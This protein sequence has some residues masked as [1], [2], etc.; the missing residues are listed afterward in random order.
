MKEILSYVGYALLLFLALTWTLGVRLKLGIAINVIFVAFCYVVACIVLPVFGFPLW[1][2]WWILPSGFV[3]AWLFIFIVAHEI[4]VLSHVIKIVST[5]FAGLV[6]I[7]VPRER[8]QAAM[9]AAN[10]QAVEE[11][12]E[13]QNG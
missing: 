2:S 3:L 11:W 6:R 7:G 10:A 5:V 1:H 4:P 13:K 8:I 12:S 9:M